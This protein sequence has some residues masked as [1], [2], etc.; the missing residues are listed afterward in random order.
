MYGLDFG[1][2]HPTVLVGLREEDATPRP[3]MLIDE[4]VFSSDL[5][6]DDLFALMEQEGV[7]KRATIYADGSRP[8]MIEGLRRAGYRGVRAADK[9]PGSVFAGITFLQK[10]RLCFTARSARSRAQF[11]DYRWQ[12]LAD[13]TVTDKPVKLDDDAPDAARYG[14]HTHYNRAAPAQGGALVGWH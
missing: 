13:G 4:V 9:S 2:K 3:Q 14:V 10:Y 11:D 6:L 7:P 12:K 1:F 5:T 8:E